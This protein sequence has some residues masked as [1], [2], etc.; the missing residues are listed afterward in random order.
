MLGCTSAVTGLRGSR[1][2]L[3]RTENNKSLEALPGL[4]RDLGPTCR[5]FRAL[6]GYWI[7]D[8][9]SRGGLLSIKPLLGLGLSLPRAVQW[10]RDFFLVRKENY[11]LERKRKVRAFLKAG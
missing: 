10:E 1:E 8:V 2:I 7:P 5:A 6:Q 3:L 11:T 9:Q 4:L